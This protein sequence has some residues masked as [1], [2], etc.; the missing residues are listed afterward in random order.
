[1]EPGLTVFDCFQNFLAL[2]FGVAAGSCITTD[3]DPGGPTTTQAFI[4][5]DKIQTGNCFFF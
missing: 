4:H 5:L 1:M 3:T 2:S